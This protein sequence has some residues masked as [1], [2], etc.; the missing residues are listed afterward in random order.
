MS[1]TLYFSLT[2]RLYKTQTC[3]FQSSLSG[4]NVINKCWSSDQTGHSELPSSRSTASGR[5]VPLGSG[6]SPN[7]SE[8]NAN[9]NPFSSLIINCGDIQSERLCPVTASISQSELPSSTIQFPVLSVSSSFI[10]IICL[11]FVFL[12]AIF[13]LFFCHPPYFF[14]VIQNFF[15]SCTFHYLFCLPYLFFVIHYILFIYFLSAIFFLSSAIYFL[16]YHLLYFL[17]YYPPY[18]FSCHLLCIFFS[19][20]EHVSLSFANC[21]CLCSHG[22]S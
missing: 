13:V 7:V 6:P 22:C 8:F 2:Q 19:V 12:L 10:R 16:I 4:S 5:V 21:V 15:L 14:F 1:E 18:L 3:L 11:L 17:I 20:I 9:L